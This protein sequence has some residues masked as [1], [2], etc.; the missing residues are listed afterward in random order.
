M[1]AHCLSGPLYALFALSLACSI[2]A[3][4]VTPGSPCASQC[5]D[6]PSGD[7][8]DRAASN[9]NTSDVACSDIDFFS[10]S[11]GS[12]FKTCVNC[13]QTSRKVE[14]DESDSAWFLCKLTE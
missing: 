14:G 4:Q 1:L 6:T 10:S 12:N 5:L 13:L 2:S 11:A 7:S 9:S 3:L 8:L